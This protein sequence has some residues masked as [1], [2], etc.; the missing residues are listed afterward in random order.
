MTHSSLIHGSGARIA[1]EYLTGWQRARADLDNFRKR[2]QVSQSDIA[3]QQLRR[4]I[5]PMLS[6]N[7]NFRAMINHV[8][9]D[10]KNNAWVSGVLHIARQLN[11]TLAAFGVT[12]IN[13]TGDPFNP[14]Q[15]EAIEHVSGSDQPSGTVVHV[16]QVGYQLGDKMLRP[17]KVKVAV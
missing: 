12:V 4:V 8:P 9:A 1:T 15:H 3:E 13:Q 17:A 14:H 16:I 11:D 7:D 2:M 5:E 10:L 6:I